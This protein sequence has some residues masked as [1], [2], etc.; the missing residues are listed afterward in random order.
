LKLVV[1]ASVAIK[2]MID[3]IDSAAADRLLDGGHDFLAPELIIAEVL[4]AA[5]KHRRRGRI[6]D[7]QFDEILIRVARGPVAYRPLKPL[8]PRAAALAR[9]LDHPVYDCFYLALAE[10]ESA[11]LTTAD[12]RLLTVVHG[13][14]LADR[15]RALA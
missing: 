5:W 6:D 15:V 7:A 14:P 11:P 13:T 2:W 12:R 10:V 9:E 1:D 3:E 8:A 4:S